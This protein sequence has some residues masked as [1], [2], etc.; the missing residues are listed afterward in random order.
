LIVHAIFIAT[1]RSSAPDRREREY[2]QAVRLVTHGPYAVRHWFIGVAVGVIV[3][4]LLLTIM[5][6]PIMWAVAAALALVGIY[7]EENIL[8][9]AGQAL[10]IS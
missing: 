5:G 3:P 6:S 1:E 7:E 9:R 4:L 10:P 8:I 2:E